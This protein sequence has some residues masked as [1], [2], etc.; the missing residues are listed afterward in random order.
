MHRKP[1]R[2]QNLAVLPFGVMLLR[3]RTGFKIYFRSFRT[4]V[5]R[6][7]GSGLDGWS[8]LVP[9]QHWSRRRG[10][11]NARNRGSAVALASLK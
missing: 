3:A 8:G 2:E 7:F 1:E 9:N 5:P 10:L 6:W 11:R 4:F